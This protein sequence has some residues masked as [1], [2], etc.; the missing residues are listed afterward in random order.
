MPF[1]LQAP[2]V[3]SSAPSGITIC[4]QDGV[5]YLVRLDPTTDLGPIPC[6]ATGPYPTAEDA[7]AAVA[8]FPPPVEQPAVPPFPS[9]PGASSGEPPA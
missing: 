8:D 4:Q 7:G 1:S 9:F 2:Y 3:V 5:F 6:T